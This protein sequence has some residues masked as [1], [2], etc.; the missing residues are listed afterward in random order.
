MTWTTGLQH[1]AGKLAARPEPALL[2]VSVVVFLLF[3]GHHL[4][5]ELRTWMSV[6]RRHPAIDPALADHLRRQSRLVTLICGTG[7]L[8]AIAMLFV[9]RANVEP[10]ARGRYLEAEQ[11]LH[12]AEDDLEKARLDPDNRDVQQARRDWSRAVD[13]LKQKNDQLGYATS[14]SQMNRSISGLNFVLVLVA[15]VAGFYRQAVIVTADQKRGY[16]GDEQRAPAERQETGGLE[17]EPQ[18]AQRSKP[19][20]DSLSEETEEAVDTQA[21]SLRIGD[22]RSLLRSRRLE[23]AE[24]LAAAHRANARGVQ[25]INCDPMREWKSVASRLQCAIPRFRAENARLRSWIQ[26]TLRHSAPDR[27]RVCG[28]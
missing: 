5:G 22:L 2:T 17:L 25:L 10:T 20:A 27:S 19:E 16:L 28:A 11:R 14:I 4:G 21:I 9:M 23:M 3:L 7:V 13:D 8:L 26:E 18:T 1:L 6:R 15:T 24:Q 12:K